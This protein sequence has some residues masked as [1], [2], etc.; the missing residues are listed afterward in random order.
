MMKGKLIII[1]V[2]SIFICTS[3]LSQGCSKQ[4]EKKSFDV[5]TDYQYQYYQPDDAYS[6]NITEDED[7][8][9]Y[10]LAGC[11]IYK[12]DVIKGSNAPLCNKAN[13]LHD[14]EENPN[15]YKDCNA[16][17]QYIGTEQYSSIAYEKGSIYIADPGFGDGWTTRI[18]RIS[19]DGAEREI[20]H[21][22]SSQF[23]N[24]I[25]HRGYFYYQEETYDK[26][27]KQSLS[28]KRYP[29]RH[30]GKSETLWQ[31]PKG[32]N[33]YGIQGIKAYGDYLYFNTTG[34][35]GKDR[36][37][38]KYFVYNIIDGQ[39]N[40]I[41]PKGYKNPLI[42]GINFFNNKILYYS[43]DGD[44]LNSQYDVDVYE[45][46]LDGTDSKKT[47]ITMPVG[48]DMYSDGKYF[49]VSNDNVL[50]ISQ[51]IN[52]QKSDKGNDAIYEVY[53][54]TYKLVDTYTEKLKKDNVAQDG[55][56]L[57]YGPIGVN[58][59]SYCIVR[60]NETG[61]VELY[62]GSKEQIGEL[63]GR[64]FDRKRLAVIKNVPAVLEYLKQ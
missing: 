14:K 17:Y 26:N 60:N 63:D 13:C 36:Y 30:K 22:F 49:V 5:M 45:C 25:F 44:H 31:F 38:N 16:Y 19:K 53:D 52:K 6:G 12:Y 62:G 34:D 20:I 46:D 43:Q 48:Y 29:L 18:I 41:K 23:L 61:V 2:L 56:K 8:N 4:Q 3:V 39:F 54:K 51:A 57:Y 11:Y 47:G 28:I 64:Q 9:L 42:F 1:S 21:Q 37:Y 59:T 35:L 50:S 7:G 10:Y 33:G 40:E 58:N 27:N 24:S 32:G 55:Y 15:R